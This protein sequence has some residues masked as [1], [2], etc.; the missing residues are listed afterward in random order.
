MELPKSLRS[1]IDMRFLSSGGYGASR[2]DPCCSISQR[3][4]VRRISFANRNS[5]AVRC[6]HLASSFY[7]SSSAP[8]CI[9][10]LWLC[11][12]LYSLSSHDK[13]SIIVFP[14]FSEILSF[15]NP[16]RKESQWHGGSRQ[17]LCNENP[18]TLTKAYRSLHTMD[19]DR[20]MVMVRPLSIQ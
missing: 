16:Q 20:A 4:S 6:G 8:A 15:C 12:S 9:S 14:S 18:P 2:A 3:L 11:R 7:P 1:A 13:A 17:F 5:T 10:F 19:G